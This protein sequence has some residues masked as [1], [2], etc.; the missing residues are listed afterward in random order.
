M[1]TTNTERE[2][3]LSATGKIIFMAGWS[4]VRDPDTGKLEV[5]CNQCKSHAPKRDDGTTNMSS[6]CPTCGAMNVMAGEQYLV[7]R[8]ESLE[9]WNRFVRFMKDANA[10]T[11][12]PGKTIFEEKDAESGKT[13]VCKHCGTPAP[14]DKNGNQFCSKYCYGC[15]KPRE[16]K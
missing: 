7:E 12:M 14:V 10:K 4:H 5:I 16:D 3:V 9:T 1:S 15:G 2:Y 8:L 6:F 11:Y 13:I